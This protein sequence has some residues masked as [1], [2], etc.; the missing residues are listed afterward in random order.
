[1]VEP[2]AFKRTGDAD[3]P[4]L[5][6]TIVMG[7]PKSGKT[8]LIASA[9]G[10]VVGDVEAGLMSIAHKNIPFVTIDEPGKLRTL[11]TV[12]GSETL[13]QQ[14]ATSL[15]LPKIE[16]FALD[17]FDRFQQLLQ[18]QWCSEHRETKFEGREAWSWLLETQREILK[19]IFALPVNVIIS[20]H[21]KT[22][23]DDDQKIINMPGVQG[24]IAEELAGYPDFSI[25]T[26][27]EID[28]DPVTG[29]RTTRY[30]LKVEGDARNPHLGN[31]AAG[32]LPEMVDSDWGVLAKAV[33][34]GLSAVA[35]PAAPSVAI[36]TTVAT[37]A[38][39]APAA[40]VVQA[41]DQ[42]AAPAV[43]AAPVAAVEAPAAAPAPV[44]A[45][46][47][48]PVATPAPEAAAP[49]V[50]TGTPAP[51]SDEDDP[52]PA[53]GVQRISSL[54]KEFGFIEPDF[55][56]MTTGTGRRIARSFLAVKKDI[57]EGKGK[58]EDVIVL[59]QA[60][61]AWVEPTTPAAAAPAPAPAPEVAPVAEAAPAPVAE[62]QS[63]PV[64]AD[65]NATPT[66]DPAPAAEATHEEAVATVKET[67][68]A[69]EDVTA[70]SVC[71][72][73]G[74][75]VDD[76]DIAILANTRYGDPLCVADYIARTKQ[77]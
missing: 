21:T 37:S 52:L 59:L 3:Y 64:A 23:Q 19:S 17:T 1:V 70:D 5:I 74:K 66:A 60:E 2:F 71:K 42:T 73:C 49:A 4:R 26:V 54:Y 6:K 61:N 27:R 12:L 29:Q 33:F 38:P 15:G 31:R 67:L 35:A 72:Q 47:V 77:G 43:V 48:A 25:M 11:I 18:K 51:P 20:V 58:P 40:E 8:T 10:V 68:G 46:A 16:T 69:T 28:V 50:A 45:P 57:I 13:R 9:P 22:V 56:A 76:V 14:A 7:P 62:V 65:V 63:A 41:A 55:S 53:Q 34:A 44:E 36:Q 32:R 75:K 30:R 24:S 39:A